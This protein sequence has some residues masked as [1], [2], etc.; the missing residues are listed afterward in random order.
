MPPYRAKEEVNIFTE[1]RVEKLMQISNST[2]ARS[3]QDAAVS[4]FKATVH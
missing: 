2:Q 4:M 3:S 1:G